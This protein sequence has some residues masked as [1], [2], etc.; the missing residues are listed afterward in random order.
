MIA[1]QSLILLIL[2]MV[3]L[4]PSAAH[5]EI[6]LEWGPILGTGLRSCT[7]ACGDLNGDGSPDLVTANI[8]SH[9]L[10]IA[11]N[12]GRGNFKEIKEIPLDQGRK[13]PVAVAIGDLDGTGNLDMA[14]A[15]VQN[16]DRNSLGT[17]AE[18]GIIFFFADEVEEFIQIYQPIAGI[19]S[20]VKIVDLDGDGDNDL[21]VG[22]NGELGI[23]PVSG[24][25]I[26]SEA[27]LYYYQN[28]GRGLF[29]AGSPRYTEGS[30]VNFLPFDYNQDGRMDVVGINQGTTDFDANFN[31]IFVDMNLSIFTGGETG[32][33]EINPQYI[34][35]FPWDLDRGDV[36]GDGV[37]DLAVSNIGD[38]YQLTSFLGTNASINLFENRST[39]FTPWKSIPM[40]GVTYAVLVDDF[41]LDGDVD[42]IATV[43]EIVNV[44]GAARLDPFLR[45]FEND[46]QGEFTQTASLPLEEEPRY[47]VKGDFDQDGDTDL[48]V[49]CV[50]IDTAGAANALNGRIYVF[51]NQ[52]IQSSLASGWELY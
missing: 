38:I 30:L 35:F 15:F 5:S 47:A 8:Y 2:G 9:S 48:A 24:R 22:N 20:S 13:H 44:G 10:T 28:R 31:F 29:S 23:D 14:A 11:Y 12:D 40:T 41:D 52:A 3:W 36:T 42:I 19:P 37:D 43:Q 50:I 4:M 45:V 18:S 26:Q 34:N 6:V 17:P 27:G 16:L 21:L 7:L 25:I 1:F 33:G 51:Y 39:R 46:G 49:L 32:L